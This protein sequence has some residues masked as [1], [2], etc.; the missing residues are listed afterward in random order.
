MQGKYINHYLGVEEASL[1]TGCLTS[2]IARCANGQIQ[3]CGNYIWRHGFRGEEIPKEIN[4]KPIIG[5]G[6]GKNKKVIYIKQNGEKII[7]NS[8]SEASR[9][10]GYS[11]NKITY[12]CE[13]YPRSTLKEG[14][15]KYEKD[16]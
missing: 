11:R 4:I 5:L 13:I 2:G 10:S 7:Y 12:N 3:H 8:L 15:F 6:K 9:Q 16:S 14:W 1:Q